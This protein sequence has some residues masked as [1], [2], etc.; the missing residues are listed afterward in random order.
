MKQ[1]KNR[2]SQTQVLEICQYI[3]VVYYMN[4]TLAKTEEG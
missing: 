2:T 4:I 3:N 1:C